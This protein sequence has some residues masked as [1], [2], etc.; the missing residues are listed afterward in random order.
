MEYLEEH[1]EHCEALTQGI[2]RNFHE[3]KRVEIE[4]ADKQQKLISIKEK[5]EDLRDTL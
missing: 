2:E 3:V 1:D 4:D 5:M